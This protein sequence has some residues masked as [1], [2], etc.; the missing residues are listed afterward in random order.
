MAVCVK[1]GSHETKNTEKQTDNIRRTYG[2]PT[3]NIR[4]YETYEEHTKSI[5]TYEKQCDDGFISFHTKPV[6]STKM[7]TL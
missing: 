7:I 6:R 2:K 5:R 3:K 1:R 4:T